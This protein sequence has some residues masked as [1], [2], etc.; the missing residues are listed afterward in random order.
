MQKN[1][2]TFKINHCKL[3]KNC[4]FLFSVPLYP[5]SSCEKSISIV[6]YLIPY[7]FPRL[8]SINLVFLP[9]DS[10][11]GSFLGVWGFFI[12]AASLLFFFPFKFKLGTTKTNTMRSR[13]L[14]KGDRA[15][16]ITLSGVRIEMAHSI[17]ASQ[18]FLEN[19]LGW[20]V[21]EDSCSWTRETYIDL[22]S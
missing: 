6:R 5:F 19:N 13:E 15:E 9:L 21:T 12:G 8:L 14:L 10:N 16:Y 17:N 2:L 22:C 3:S 7:N 1:F 18:T 20:T 11:V 4:I